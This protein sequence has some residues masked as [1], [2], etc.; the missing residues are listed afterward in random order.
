ML[1][2]RRVLRPLLG[3]CDVNGS[4]LWLNTHRD[5]CRP[6]E[7]WDTL[8]L[9]RAMLA[10]PE[11]RQACW[12]HEPLPLRPPPAVV[13]ISGAHHDTDE[14]YAHMR[15][16]LD[17]LDQIVVVVHSDEASLFKW[18]LVDRPGITWWISTPRHS[19]H[20]PLIGQARFFGEGAGPAVAL[21][22]V[23]KDL[24]VAFLGQINHV[25]RQELAAVMADMDPERTLFEDTGGF[26]QG[27]P[28]AGFMSQM[29]RAKIAPCPA[30]I[31]SVD[32]FRLYQAIEAGCVPVV[33]RFDRHGNDERMW[34]M[35]YGDHFPVPMVDSWDELPALVDSLLVGWEYEAEKCQMWLD[36]VERRMVEN[37]RADLRLP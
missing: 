12:F 7:T 1:P 9:Q 4:I 24:D 28:H 26:L 15:G 27:R 18:W 23:E 5:V 14:D 32:S 30:G 11:L 8:G 35:V 37:L 2:C 6:L 17:T 16:V 10:V 22:A 34:E 36:G 20:A 31:E 13:L 21:P 29:A 33:E 3:G 19:V 25:R